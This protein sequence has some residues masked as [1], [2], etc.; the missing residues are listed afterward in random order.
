VRGVIGGKGKHVGRE[1]TSVAGGYEVE[2]KISKRKDGTLRREGQDEVLGR[3]LGSR[4]V[5]AL[6]KLPELTKSQILVLLV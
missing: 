5:R 1:D 4:M 2:P 3:P 6:K